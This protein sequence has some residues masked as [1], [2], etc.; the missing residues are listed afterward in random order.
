MG[1]PHLRAVLHG[2][3]G[4]LG[5]LGPVGDGQFPAAPYCGPNLIDP[6]FPT[7]LLTFIVLDI[8]YIGTVHT[9]RANVL[10]T[11]WCSVHCALE[12]TKKDYF[13][14]I[15]VKGSWPTAGWN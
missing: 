11:Y 9:L 13:D 1:S 7:D 8:S 12:I 2:R 15:T 6:P 3:L 10:F 4:G 14:E 5:A